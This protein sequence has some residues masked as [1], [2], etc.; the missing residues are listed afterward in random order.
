[1]F[2]GEYEVVFKDHAIFRADERGIPREVL[3]ATIQTGEFKRFGKRMVKISR[4]HGDESVTCVG[5]IVGNCIRIITITK[6]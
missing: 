6:G 2:K 4:K 1:L 3:E 5:E